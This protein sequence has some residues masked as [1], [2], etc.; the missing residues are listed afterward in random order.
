MCFADDVQEDHSQGSD[1]DLKGYKVQG[2]PRSINNNVNDNNKN[3]LTALCPVKK[4]RAHGGAVGLNKIYS[5]IVITSSTN[6]YRKHK[7]SMLI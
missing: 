7:S 1:K 4:G 2:A 6:K 3:S 5:F